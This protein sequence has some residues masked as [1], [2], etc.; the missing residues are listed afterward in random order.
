MAKIVVLEDEASTRRLITAVLKKAGHEVT[1][2]DNGAEGL[3]TVLAELPDLVVSDVEMP[4][5]NGFEVLSDIRNTPETAQTPVIL[6][7]SRSS[8]EDISHGMSQGANAYLTKPFDPNKLLAAVHQQLELLVSRSGQA[9]QPGGTGFE[10]TAPA[11]LLLTPFPSLELEP[12]QAPAQAAD[13]AT[14]GRV[15]QPP[16]QQFAAAWAVSM[17]VHNDQALRQALPIQAWRTLL[18]QL[19]LPVSKDAAL[20]SAD[21]LDLHESRLTLYFL[22]QALEGKPGYVRAAQAVQAMLR[23]S[24]QAKQ[25]ITQQPSVVGAPPLRVLT[26]LHLGPIEVV[27]MPLDFGGTR[28]T[29]VGDTAEFMQ[30][31]RD[32][33]PRVAWR[34]LG[35]AAAV[36]A[37]P[38]TYRLGAQIDISV[39][40]QEV[41]VHALQ[42][43]NPALAQGEP[44]DA[45]A[46][47]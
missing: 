26:S 22:D 24:V 15:V 21:Y 7:T 39:G 12:M 25:W 6:L 37:S 18:R 47:I 2:V 45:S 8:E 35:T 44:L 34:V 28:D 17:E 19:F 43:M 20:R 42:D 3:L 40:S 33:E 36:A 13:S 32:G 31:L 11:E 27:R 5:I 16:R 46:W 23:S 38:N 29:V 9:S 10:A 4:K 1:D 30:R 41:Q 14:E